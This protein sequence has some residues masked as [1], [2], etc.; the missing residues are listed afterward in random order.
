MAGPAAALNSDK[1]RTGLR[2]TLLGHGRLYEKP[3]KSDDGEAAWSTTE[4]HKGELFPHRISL[5]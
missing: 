3:R 5:V 2:E 4:V 1:V